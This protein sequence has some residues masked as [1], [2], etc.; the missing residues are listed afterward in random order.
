[1]SYKAATT[2]ER[3]RWFTLSYMYLFNVIF[4]FRLQ[5]RDRKKMQANIE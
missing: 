4:E 2:R 5:T 1:M 3:Q